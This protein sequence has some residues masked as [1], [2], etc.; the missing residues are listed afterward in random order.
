MTERQR[1]LEYID[2]SRGIVI[3][4][5]VLGHLAPF[6]GHVFRI[7]FSFHM[8]FFFFVSGYCSSLAWKN[9]GFFPFLC[10]ISGRYI[11]PNI[12]Y[13]I[14]L[15]VIGYVKPISVSDG[16]YY[17][18]I[19]PLH[20][21]FLP[22]LFLAQFFFY[23]YICL[24]RFLKKKKME[25]T[26]TAFVLASIFPLIIY[27]SERGW[28][29]YPY[30]P[31]KILSAMAGFVFVVIGF[32]V[33]NE[34]PELIDLGRAKMCKWL[35]V[36]VSVLLAVMALKNTYLNMANIA[37]G[38]SDM[39]YVFTAVFYSCTV[40]LCAKWLCNCKRDNIIG[41]TWWMTFI[42]LLGRNSLIVYLAQG[43]IFY[44]LNILFERFTGVLYTPMVDFPW[45]MVGIYF[46]ITVISCTVLC[47]I[48]ELL[49]RNIIMRR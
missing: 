4:L 12:C 9:T 27:L 38:R 3:L 40:I 18:F 1:R 22:A 34:V 23:W 20:E 16:L 28:H 11:V 25:L 36:V 24:Y 46:V 14:I 44:L 2:V 6:D 15:I 41:V 21:W 49:K 7:I 39:L 33:R 26:G 47:K 35:Y 13:S 29:D 42:C 17:I 32:W 31:V 19:N 37:F 5:M 45:R 30:F 10:K 8:P 48:W 43:I